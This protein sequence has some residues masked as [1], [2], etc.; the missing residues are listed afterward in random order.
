MDSGLVLVERKGDFFLSVQLENT[1][2]V[3]G[4]LPE[5]GEIPPAPLAPEALA[6]IHLPNGREGS[7]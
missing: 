5:A 2:R 3:R 4:H 1:R 7:Q 6:R